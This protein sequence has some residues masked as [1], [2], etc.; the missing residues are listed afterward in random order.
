MIDPVPPA[1]RTELGRLAA[2]WHQLPVGQAL[3]RA[4]F[5]RALAQRYADEAA[6]ARGL[7]VRDLP[8]LGP[9][10]LMDQLAVT[11][12]DV[13]RLSGPPPAPGGGPGPG[14]GG[15]EAVS[16]PPGGSAG[17]PGG[18]DAPLGSVAARTVATELA[19]LRRLL[20]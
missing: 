2:R 11:V 15:V 4:P 18:A 13:C 12:Y 5:V 10:V 3:S 6:A 7:P 16:G 20:A 17:P 8:D 1:A 9:G 19:D 14:D